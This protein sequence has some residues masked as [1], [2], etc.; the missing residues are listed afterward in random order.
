MKLATIAAFGLLALAALAS[1]LTCPVGSSLNPCSSTV[2]PDSYLCYSC[3]FKSPATGTFSGGCDNS[4][5]VGEVS[6][7][8][9][10]AKITTELYVGC[11]W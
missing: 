4:V 6:C 8:E 2:V 11:T 5:K 1:A 7:V 10:K 9:Q 3:A